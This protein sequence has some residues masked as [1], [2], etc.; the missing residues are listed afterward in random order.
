MP[1]VDGITLCKQ[2]R[3]NSET[4]H[5]P[6]IMQTAK[7]ELQTKAFEACAT[8]FIHKPIDREELIVRTLVHLENARM[9]NE[10]RNY[11]RQMMEELR[12]AQSMQ[13]ML[14]PS[15]KFLK[16]VSEETDFTLL[17]HQ[18]ALLQIGGDFWGCKALSKEKLAIYIVDISG[19]GITAALNAFRLHA[20]I[21]ESMKQFADQPANYLAHLN[22]R[23]RS[24][25][26][27]G[28][29]A[30]M[31]Y[32]VINLKEENLIYSVAASTQG[33]IF[34]AQE[35]KVEPF[36]QKGFPLGIVNNADFETHKITFKKGDSL[37]L[38]SD[39][40]IETS[41]NKNTVLDSATL[42]AMLEQGLSK[43]TSESFFNNFVNYFYQHYARKLHDDL[44]TTLIIEW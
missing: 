37:M 8:D 11:Q 4:E 13:M 12:H 15:K 39:A 33:L 6:I 2:L 27:A 25:I 21:D 41:N 20:L 7:K 10:L 34:R 32:G 35:Q 24:F 30:T 5:L 17:C 40:L 23:L 16:N 19:H 42:I 28:Q 29:Y 36:E 18:H 43:E 26:T 1:K 38:Y 44:H 14:Q 22:T 3:S 31:F 9:L